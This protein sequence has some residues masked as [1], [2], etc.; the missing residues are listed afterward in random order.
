MHSSEPSP[1]VRE[2]LELSRQFVDGVLSGPE[3]ERRFLDARRNDW[4]VTSDVMGDVLS[5]LM[6]AVDDYV[7]EDDLREPDKGDIDENQLRE[8]VRGQLRRLDQT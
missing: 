8:L 5:Q 4:G 7:A 1:S 3:F 6:F 2:Q